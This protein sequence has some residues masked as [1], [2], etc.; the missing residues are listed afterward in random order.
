MHLK[1]LELMGFKSF[2]KK[3]V[4]EFEPGITA[5]IGP[6]GSGKSNICD[7]LRWVLGE[8]SAKALRGNKMAEVI[9]AGSTPIAS[10]VAPTLE[11]LNDVRPA[12]FA[13]VKL[14]F[15]NEDRRIPVDF[16]EV[17]IG[18]ELFRSGESNYY[19]NNSRTLLSD[20]KEMLMDTGIGKEGY[21]VIGQGDID[22][23]VFQRGQSRRTLIEEAAGITKFRHRKTAAV[24]K[25]EH[26]RTNIT[27]LRDITGEIENQLIP[28]EEQAAKTRRFQTLAGEI[29]NLEID[30]LL[31]DLSQ[32]LGEQEN[33]D[34]MRRGLLAKISEIQNFLNEINRR[35]IETMEKFSGFE[36]TLKNRTE[37]IRELSGHM[38][39][40]RE[41]S[42][43]LKEDLRS[44]QARREAIS[45]EMKEIEKL[46]SNG[47]LEVAAAEEHLQ[48]EKAR[49]IETGNR[50][51]EIE[52]NL[53]NAR[54]QLSDHL[55]NV[56]QDKESSFQVAVKMAEK[57]NRITTSNQQIQILER[58]LEKSR[59]DFEG[60]KAQ[61]EKLESDKT[62]IQTEIESMQVQI[63][64]NESGLAS[65]RNSLQKTETELRRSEEELSS[66]SDRMKILHARRNLLDELKNSSESG[67]FRGVRAAISFKERG[68]VQGIF[69]MVGDLLKVPKGYET[70][71]ETALG[72]SIQ[73]I[74][75]RDADTAQ[76][77][78]SLL[79]K[80]RMGRATFLPLDM[81]NPPPRISSPSSNGCLGVALD[82]IEYDPKFYNIMNHLL[83]R[84]LIFK[85]LDSAIIYAKKERNFNRIV[86]LDGE[87]VRSSGAMTGGSEGNRT[88]GL[89]SRK[90]EQEEA[91]EQI[92]SL[93]ANEKRL[94]KVIA[95]LKSSRYEFMTEVR[96][97]EDELARR[98]QSLGFFKKSLEKTE[99]EYQTR[100]TEF[101]R[102]NNDKK[103]VEN[104]LTRHIKIL[105]EARK[106]SADL[107]SRNQELS[108][109]L[110]ALSSRE[111]SIQTSVKTLTSMMNDERL[112]EAQV[113]ERIK[114]FEKEMESARKRYGDAKNR[115]VR[116]EREITRLNEA[117]ETA[118]NNIEELRKQYTD[119]ENR[120]KTLEAELSDLQKDYSGCSKELESLDQTYQSR[121][122]IE[123]TTRNKLAE[124]DIR[125]AEIKTHIRN[126]QD[127]LTGDFGFEVAQSGA[128]LRKYEGREDIQQ[129]IA[130]RRQEQEIL[131]PVNPMA[132][133][134]F[135]K[136]R[137]RFDFLNAQIS[138]LNDAAVS[139][140][141]VISEIEKIS[142]ERF[143]ETFSQ[144]DKAFL[145]IFQ[146]LFPGGEA[147]LKLTDR[148]NPLTSDIDIICRLPGKKLTNIELFSG[149]E[150]ALVSIALLFAILNVKPPAFCILDEVEASLDEANVKRFTRLV[151]SAAEKTQF[152]IITH[153]KE[154]MQAVDVIYGITLHKSGISRPVSIRLEDNEKITQFTR[155]RTSSIAEKA[156][157]NGV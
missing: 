45:D 130:V 134:E 30:L 52:E 138:D 56:A 28:L 6:N 127:A 58:Q 71:F 57:K 151:K 22:E 129:R 147:H 145:D 15:D 23:V 91:E 11:P 35:K 43:A 17:A 77:V 114:S 105:E 24:Q 86:T 90:R 36:S 107:E 69:G 7:A 61:T 117:I 79:K 9:F 42:S 146:L 137:E 51:R 72:G 104:E 121:V 133:E 100:L 19:L 124:L 93:A 83:G 113:T 74:V 68:E 50:I 12:A 20:I 78:I 142:A 75:T 13:R 116:S 81:I 73:D 38:D 67:I 157:A 70:A 143:L 27:R 96:K 60:F 150:K 16:S 41:T 106:E 141:Q 40:I 76:T 98:L 63:S 122:R 112:L 155:T 1:S 18:R 55:K 152:L 149:G 156:I 32:L 125:L 132:I 64:A 115:L 47:D 53:N 103:D 37:T 2:G 5:I 3:T 44:H 39:E 80:S 99:S 59:Y 49:G 25:L 135:E 144:I 54:Q 46:L 66:T 29:R 4:F 123:E 102:L 101:N 34:S 95:N 21:S 118:Y 82:L 119:L 88:G 139:L 48:E 33:I 140:E 85:D 31:F 94:V 26:T 62:K 153:N 111:E 8:Q 126:K 10:K 131:Q 97:N 154:T 65:N 110:Q 84:I 109:R 92:K 14:L 89:L 128:S 148:N 136:T 120:K 87:I 108:E